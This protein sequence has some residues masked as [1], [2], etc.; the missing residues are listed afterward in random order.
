MKTKIFLIIALLAS[1]S[2]A[3]VTNINSGATH[4]AIQDAVTAASSG[5][6]L[7]V[8][9]GN[10]TYMSVANKNLTIIGGYTPDFSSQVNYYNTILDGYSYCADFSRSTSTVEGLTFTGSSRGM[11]VYNYSVV[12]SVHCYI[13]DNISYQVGAGAS[14]HGYGRLV[15]DHTDVENNSAT[16]TTGDGT[17]G[18]IYV[19]QG[20]LIVGDYSHIRN[21][22]AAEKGGG[23]YASMYAYVEVN[24]NSMIYGNSTVEAG[25]GL[26]LL[27][28][29]LKAHTNGRLGYSFGD[30][31]RSL[32]DG[33]G[34]FARNSTITFRDNFSYLMNSYAG[35]NGGGAYVSNC[36]VVFYNNSDL[37]YDAYS[38]TNYAGNHGGGIYAIASTIALSNA[39]IYGCRSNND[40]GA[41]YARDSEVILYHCN[42]GS[43]ND[44]YVNIA[45]DDAAVIDAAGG[46]IAVNNSLFYNNIA[47]DNAGCIMIDYTDLVIT[48]SIFRNNTAGGRGGMLYSRTGE[49]TAEISDSSILTNSSA[50]NGGAIYWASDEQLEISGGSVVAANESHASGGAIYLSAGKLEIKNSTFNDNTADSNNNGTGNGG[51]I[52]AY[53]ATESK[54]VVNTGQGFL[55]NSAINGGVIFA[56]GSAK[57]DVE[58]TVPGGFSMNFNNATNGGAFYISNGAE[59]QIFGRVQMFNNSAINGGTFF[60]TN[61]ATALI[62]STNG[63][64]PEIFGGTAELNGGGA[65]LTGSDSSLFMKNVV[66]GKFGSFLTRNMA[67]GTLGGGGGIALYDEAKMTAINCLFQNNIS[68][69][70]GGAIYSTGGAQTE[71]YG[72]FLGPVISPPCVFSNNV[73]EYGAVFY[74]AG[75]SKISFND[76]LM[77][78]NKANFSGGGGIAIESS[79]VNVENTIIALNNAE[80]AGGVALVTSARGLMNYCTVAM[81]SSNGVETAMG[82]SVTISNTIVWGNAGNQVSSAQSVSYSD[83]QGGYLGD[84][85]IDVAPEFNNPL[86]KDFSLLGTSPCIDT[87]VFAGVNYDCVHVPRPYGDG[88]DIG[89]YEFVPEPCCLLFIVGN[90]F[91]LVSRKNKFIT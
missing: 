58:T 47:D 29:E 19:S 67:N 4:S 39:N 89:A 51:A 24:N 70:K 25:G 66:M 34:I 45:G 22:Y 56:N 87:G 75:G 64:K 60:I 12:T 54:I 86:M 88:Y 85:N 62:V 90:L 3:L 30:A 78:E 44:E 79:T 69:N 57:V 59:L 83:V 20:D 36:S 63:Y 72:S 82:G 49:A 15:L 55:R 40:G 42:V 14:V 33:G 31:N 18:G 77:L 73:A 16:N 7:L 91:F 10:Y 6:T 53:S 5:D 27:N 48:N 43:T 81:N 13:E 84:G 38:K 80:H 32:G 61:G 28:S 2:F 37:G 8:S 35:Y 68:K 76:T 41:I 50:G 17:G 74:V 71:V 21:N 1:T 65:F 9:T 23:I 11:H 26:Y 52:Y 46:S